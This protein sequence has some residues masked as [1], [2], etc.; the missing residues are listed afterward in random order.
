MVMSS[1]P[2]GTAGSPGGVPRRPRDHGVL[3]SVAGTAAVGAATVSAVLTPERQRLPSCHQCRQRLTGR[4]LT[5]PAL[6]VTREF[7]SRCPRHHCTVR[8]VPHVPGTRSPSCPPHCLVM[9]ARQFE[10]AVRFPTSLLHPRTAAACALGPDATA[11]AGPSLR[12]KQGGANFL[13]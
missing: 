9:P 8:H 13:I 11:R 2:E 3:G 5:R 6:V 1:T 10:L 12:L 7:D 4:R